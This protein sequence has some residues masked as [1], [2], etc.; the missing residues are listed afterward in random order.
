MSGSLGQSVPPQS[1]ELH[2]HDIKQL[3]D[4]MDP[5]PFRERS[6][7]P[8]AEECIVNWAQELEPGA[9]LI[10]NI[11]LEKPPGHGHGEAA[12]AVGD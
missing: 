9:A 11:L 3:F 6:L 8:Q 12:A 10:L 5:S 4:F 2:L 1:V 7:D